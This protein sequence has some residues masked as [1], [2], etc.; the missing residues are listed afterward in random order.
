DVAARGIDISGLTHV[1]NYSIP[2]DGATYVHRIG[3]TGRA[4]SSG[5]AVTFVRPEE[6][7]KLS[8]LQRAVA[9]ASKGQMVEEEVPTVHDVLEAKRIRIVDELTQKVW[10]KIENVQLTMQNCDEKEESSAAERTN[11]SETEE[12]NC[13]LS[14]VN[15]QL[16]KEVDPF[17]TELA[18]KLINGGDAKA[19]LACVLADE[20][21]EK[22]S[23]KHYGKITNPKKM[24]RS[25]E[26]DPNSMRIFVSLGKKDHMGPRDIADFFSNLLHIPGRKVDNIDVAREFSL[27]SL[28][29]ESAKKALDMAKS[30]KNLPHM[31]ID[32]KGE[33]DR[34]PR[35][36]GA[37]KERPEGVSSKEDFGKGSERR[38]GG[39]KRFDD[40]YDGKNSDGDRR[41]GRSKGNRPNPHTQSTR[42]AASL[43]KKSSKKAERF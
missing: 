12:N 37:Y 32:T 16:P 33:S 36:R 15:C 7:R 26:A 21:G 19:V 38:R 41:E 40:H 5:T 10:G 29:K 4:G 27:V 35:R 20:F 6:R 14:T 24:G 43:Y 30:N 11:M 18:E 13:Q 9:K 28:P 34:S 8:F 39:G 31:H 42:N 17:F 23:P 3:R 1:V 2:F 22:L 25:F